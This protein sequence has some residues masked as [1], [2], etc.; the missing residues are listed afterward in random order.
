[1]SIEAIAARS[2]VG[3]QAIYRRWR[4]K[5]EVILDAFAA[6]ADRS[7]QLPDTG[8]L[9]GDLTAVLTDL[10]RALQGDAATVNRALMAEALRDPIFG[11]Q[12]RDGFIAL[13]RDAL[14]PL[15][16]RARQRGEMAADDDVLLDLV[17]GPMW[18]RLLV[19]HG[20]LDDAYARELAEAVAAAARL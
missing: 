20:P 2:G 15:L 17:Y 18:Y 6:R 3:K 12:L 10:F 5:G 13:R 16:E 19:G 7:L 9:V 4:G 14:R 8:S 11:A 1:V